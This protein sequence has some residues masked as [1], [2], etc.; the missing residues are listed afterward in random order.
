MRV[1]YVQRDDAGTRFDVERLTAREAAAEDLMLGMRMTRGV[2]PELLGRARALAGEKNVVAAVDEALARG[3]A[4]W[5]PDG[6]LAPTERGWLL[7]NELY[8]LM[9]DLAS[10]D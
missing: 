8:G 10:D 3:L 9:W 7:G 6:R 5:A 2:G 1:R 4:A